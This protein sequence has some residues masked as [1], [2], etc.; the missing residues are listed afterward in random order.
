MPRRGHVHDEGFWNP[1]PPPYTPREKEQAVRMVH[2]LREELGA[3]QGTVRRLADQFAKGESVRGWVLCRRRHKTQLRIVSP[4]IPSAASTNVD[5]E[6][7]APLI[8]AGRARLE[9]SDPADQ[10]T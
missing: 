8:P 7:S 10:R 4:G 3:S 5:P 1:Q 6:T 9:E 2:A